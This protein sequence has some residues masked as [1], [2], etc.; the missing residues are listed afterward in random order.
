MLAAVGMLSTQA[1]ADSTIMLG[2][3]LQVSAANVEVD[4]VLTLVLLILSEMVAHGTLKTQ[5]SAVN[6]TMNSSLLQMI[7]A[8]ARLLHFN[9]NPLICQ[10]SNT[11]APM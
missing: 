4:T 3:M 11:S 2:S 9:F 10:P 7:A 1:H 8:L 6:L 5:D